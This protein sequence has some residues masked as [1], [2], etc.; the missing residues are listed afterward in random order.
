MTGAG[1][2]LVTP[3]SSTVTVVLAPIVLV[4]PRKQM[5]MLSALPTPQLPTWV[6]PPT[7]TLLLTSVRT[8]VVP[9][10]VMVIW[11]FALPDIPPV[12]EVVNQIV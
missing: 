5:A 12:L 11:L 10:S 8:F 2:S 1:V 9:G 4:E 3:S 6:A 7:V